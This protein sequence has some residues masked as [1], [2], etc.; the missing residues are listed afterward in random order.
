MTDGEVMR[1]S[2]ISARLQHAS[3]AVTR[4]WIRDRGLKPIEYRDGVTGEKL[5]RRDEVEEA[6]AST[7]QRGPYRRARPSAE[8]PPTHDHDGVPDSG[9]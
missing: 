1:T 2:E 9:D 5:Y 7:V 3:T 6:I 4:A 8:G